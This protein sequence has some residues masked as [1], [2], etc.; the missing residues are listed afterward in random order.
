MR[1]RNKPWADDF[2]NEHSEYIISNPEDYLG[3]WSTRFNNDNPIHIEIGSGKGQFIVGMAKKNPNINYIGIE[4]QKNVI[5]MTLQKVV[6]EE[7]ENVQLINTD[8]KSVD[9]FF[10]LGEIQKIYLNFSDPWPK[11]RH[12]KRR[13]TSPEF[14]KTYYNILNDKSE[15]EFKTDNRGLFEYSLMSL[16]NFGMTFDHVNLNLHDSEELV[17]NVET[18]YEAKFKSKG[19]IYKILALVN[20]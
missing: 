3:K 13:L 10:S 6:A 18:E 2:I 16:N 12:I 20:K 4:I 15:I 14:L 5:A 7:L 19:P 17:D 9:N 1:V 8:G 11:T